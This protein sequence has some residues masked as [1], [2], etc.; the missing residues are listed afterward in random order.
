MSEFVKPEWVNVSTNKDSTVG[1]EQLI[2][3]NDDNIEYEGE[4]ITKL[5]YIK[6]HIF[7]GKYDS[8]SI[9]NHGGVSGDY[10]QGYMFG[11]YLDKD[12]NDRASLFVSDYP[13]GG[14]LHPNGNIASHA[15]MYIPDYIAS[16]PYSS[17]Y[18]KLNALIQAFQLDQSINDRSLDVKSF[19]T[20]CVIRVNGYASSYR[21]GTSVT[22]LLYDFTNKEYF[23]FDPYL[24]NIQFSKPDHYIYSKPLTMDGSAGRSYDNFIR[25]QSTSELRYTKVKFIDGV[26]ATR[27]YMLTQ[28]PI[29]ATD[30]I[31]HT[32]NK[33]FYVLPYADDNHCALAIECS[34]DII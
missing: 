9:I 15:Y 10:Q 31:L 33:N 21:I 6:R 8:I 7:N 26:E 17:Q 20:F 23:I 1:I 25:T 28:L 34:A 22:V 14:G 11:L 24:A 5:D 19:N 27:V 16:Y 32:E 2:V 30:A 4:T 13:A 3:F 18:W 12:N 29:R